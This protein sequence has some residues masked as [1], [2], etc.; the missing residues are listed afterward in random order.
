V[1]DRRYVVTQTPA[2]GTWRAYLCAWVVGGTWI[3]EGVHDVPVFLCA[4][5]QALTFDEPTARQLVD[6][7][8]ARYR[9]VVRHHCLRED[10]P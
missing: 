5:D 9:R 2:S 8:D 6:R 3:R 7:L 4:R 10:A 1:S